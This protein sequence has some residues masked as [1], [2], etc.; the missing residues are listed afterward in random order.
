MDKI[1]LFDRQFSRIM[2]K[3][4]E[5]TV[6]CERGRKKD[7]AKIAAMFDELFDVEKG[8]KLVGNRG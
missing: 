8:G 2:A 7:I 3:L 5:L 4:K 1:E 6:I